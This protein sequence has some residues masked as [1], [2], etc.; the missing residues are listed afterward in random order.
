VGHLLLF[1][2]RSALNRDIR[3]ENDLLMA[4]HQTFTPAELFRIGDAPANSMLA[5]KLGITSMSELRH[6]R[7][8]GGGLPRVLIVPARLA[9]RAT[10]EQPDCD[11][12][13]LFPVI[14][15]GSPF[16]LGKNYH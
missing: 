9:V 16:I 4:A 1:R 13:A 11:H 7:R 12:H 6:Y 5:E 3:S 10:A 2:D 15:N 14:A 8:K